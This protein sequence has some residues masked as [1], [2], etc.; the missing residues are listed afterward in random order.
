MT[1]NEQVGGKIVYLSGPMSGLPDLN[2]AAFHKAAGI[3]RE[4]GATVINPAESFGGDKTLHRG[5]YF[6][7]DF[8]VI[9]AVCDTMVMLPGWMD[10]RG[11]KGEIVVASLCELGIYQ[12]DIE[13]VPGDPD[14]VFFGLTRIFVQDF[15]SFKIRSHV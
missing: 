7:H 13:A 8:A 14:D 9:A 3:L 1:M 2:Y 5:Q 15:S 6:R 4:E 11:A 10:S 12:A